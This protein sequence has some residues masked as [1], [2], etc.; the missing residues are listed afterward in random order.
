MKKNPLISVVMPVYNSAHTVPNAI[1]SI[2]NQ[3]YKNWELIIVDDGSDDRDLLEKNIMQFNDS[4]IRFIRNIHKGV[5]Y[6]RMTGYKAA[7]GDLLAVQDADDLSLPDRLEKAV[8]YFNEFPDTDVF[9]HT[10][11]TNMWHT[12]FNCIVR[13]FRRIHQTVDKDRLL[14]EQYIPGYP[15]F[16]K[17]VI[18]KKPLREETKNIYDWSFL[19]DWVFSDFK[20]GFT[21]EALYEYVRQQNSLSEVNEREGKR[22]KSLLVMKEIMK[23]EYDVEFTP[24]DWL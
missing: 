7:K 14:K 13:D 15:I 10:A 5:V 21:D 17:H 2:E 24:N 3:T 1:M 23:K 8:E 19:L 4:R 18:K 11:Y 16:K 9:C 12:E 6:T 20:F 22:Q